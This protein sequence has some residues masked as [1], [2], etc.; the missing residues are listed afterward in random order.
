MWHYRMKSRIRSQ[1]TFCKTVA[2]PILLCE[3]ETWIV[4]KEDATKKFS[5]QK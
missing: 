1:L 3:S 2:V 5:Q 4:K